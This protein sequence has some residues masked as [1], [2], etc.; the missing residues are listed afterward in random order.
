MKNF[1]KLALFSVSVVLIFAFCAGGDD[2]KNGYGR[3]YENS[4]FAPELIHEKKLEPFFRTTSSLYYGDAE[5]TQG[6]YKQNVTDWYNY[7]DKQLD[8]TSIKEI[9]YSST[10][11]QIDTL[12]FFL[13]NPDTKISQRLRKKAILNYSDKEKSLDFLFYLGFALR[14]EIF[15]NHGNDDWTYTPIIFKDNELLLKLIKGGIRQGINL[16]SLFIKERYL[17]QVVRLLYFNEDYTGCESFFMKNKAFFTP[18]GN[19]YYRALGYVAAALY[20]R[21]V[22][23]MSNYY[24]SL[25]FENCELMQETALWSFH[26]QEEKDFKASLF[27]AKNNKEKATILF[28]MGYL[29]DATRAIKEILALNINSPY[30]DVLLTRAINIEE[31]NI[32]NHSVKELVDK[33][34]NAVLIQTIQKGLISPQNKK[35]AVWHLALGYLYSLSNDLKN[36]EMQFEEAESKSTDE[37][38]KKSINLYRAINKIKAQTILNEKTEIELLPSILL[39][40]EN[41]TDVYLRKTMAVQWLSSRFSMIYKQQKEFLKAECWQTH[42]VGFYYED[43]ENLEKT[44]KFINTPA[45]NDYEKLLKKMYA[46][47]K[48]RLLETQAII[49]VYNDNLPESIIKLESNVKAGTDTLLGDP[50]IIHIKDCH[51]CDHEADQKE[52]F[53]ILSFLKRINN[54]KKESDRLTN[55]EEKAHL[56]FEVAN[57]YYNIT[58]FGNARKFYQ[59]SIAYN[60]DVNFDYLDYQ[61]EKERGML[62]SKIYDC[63]LAAIY[64]KKALEMS[65]NN[66]FKAMCTFMLAKCEQNEFYRIRPKDYKGDFKAGKYFAELKTNYKQT[67]YYQEIIH[68][69]GYFDTYINKK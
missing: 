8:T 27:L 35:N 54:K 64:Y 50:F 48:D 56:L 14:C 46:F 32:L 34:P 21:K 6:F 20:K 47:S 62:K 51:D 52:K 28:M 5:K 57:A 63:Q 11:P 60:Y 18:N 37:L 1:L 68:E 66:E 23:S 49:N 65:N 4:L 13:K 40:L 19:I 44:I 26:P 67:K 59:T 15:A 12:I 25:I 43:D 10:L 9:L 38:L 17:F 69:C 3:D 42:S 29:N 45:K 58:N 55:V 39:I 22:Y 30:L 41:D 7:F 33:K 61:S 16:K 31:E 2:F 53:T 36:A 24:Y